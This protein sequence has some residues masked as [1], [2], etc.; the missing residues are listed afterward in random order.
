M[1]KYALVSV[2]AAAMSFGMVASSQAK[3]HHSPHAVQHMERA[4]A[5]APNDFVALS[6]TD[7]ATRGLSRRDPL[8]RDLGYF[9]NF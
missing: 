2:V 5:A 3:G 9:R 6:P 8:D 4:R 1:I 7:A